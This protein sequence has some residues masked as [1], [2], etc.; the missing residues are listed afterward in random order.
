MSARIIIGKFFTL[1]VALQILNLS[2]DVQNHNLTLKTTDI[3]QF[4]EMNSVA[5]FIGEKML[6]HDNAF[7]ENP[8]GSHKDVQFNKHT[9]IKISCNAALQL[10]ESPRNTPPSFQIPLSEDYTF[11]Y[12]REINPPPPKYC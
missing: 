9:D 11:L 5:E 10:Q 12:F 3:A 2:I 1:I 7:P 6:N 8:K 4:N